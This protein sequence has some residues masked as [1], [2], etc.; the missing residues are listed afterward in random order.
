MNCTKEHKQI[1]VKTKLISK[2][3]NPK[4]KRQSITLDYFKISQT[5]PAIDMHK[6]LTKKLKTNA[7]T[8]FFLF[9]ILTMLTYLSIC[10]FIFVLKCRCMC[11]SFFT[12]VRACLICSVKIQIVDSGPPSGA[13]R[14]LLHNSKNFKS[15]HMR[16][17]M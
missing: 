2:Y 1:S 6:K 15:L 14:G 5:K 4:F 10:L 8:T 7:T 17:N 12:Y 9:N 3:F 11:I 16:E 13:G